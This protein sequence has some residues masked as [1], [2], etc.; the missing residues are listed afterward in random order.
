MKIE[1]VIKA[2]KKLVGE[3]AFISFAYDKVLVSFMAMFNE[4]HYHP[5][6]KIWE[7]PSTDL[8]TFIKANRKGNSFHIQYQ[9]DGAVKKQEL[10]AIPAHYS[11]KLKPFKHQIEAV[12]FALTNPRYLLADEQG[13]GKTKSCIDAETIRVME[14]GR[15]KCLIL[16][17][18]NGSKWNWK[19]EVKNN[20]YL[21]ARVLGQLTRKNGEEYVGRTID[22]VADLWNAHEHFLITNMESLRS[23]EFLTAL[24]RELKVGKIGSIIFDEIH[25]CGNPQSQQG[26]GLLSLSAPN[27]VAISGTPILNH[28]IDAFAVLKWLGKETHSMT[29]FKKHYCIMGGFG[30]N[31]ILGY[32]NM[33]ELRNRIKEIEL[34]RLKVDCL[35][36]PPKIHSDEFLEMGAKQRLIYQEIL[37]ELRANIDKIKMSPNPLTQMLRLRQATSYTGILSTSILESIK[38]DRAEQIVEEIA[39]TGGK[40]LIFSNWVEVLRPLTERLARFNPA[41]MT[42]ETKKDVEAQKSKF[43]N[44][45]SCKLCIGT[46]GFMGTSHTLTAAN[47]VIFLDEPWNKG[48]K[49]QAEDR[50]YRIGTRGTVN[51]ITLR[52][53]GTIDE[54]IARLLETKGMYADFLV[55]GIKATGNRGDL[56]EFLLS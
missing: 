51:I 12:R 31:E 19:K 18:V 40:C 13:L 41:I 35:D 5:K 38:F 2:G 7:I 42:G 24:Q 11:W 39:E 29:A 22:K 36:L 50:A 20:S 54:K 34:R 37:T 1:I 4:R 53:K 25:R 15:G 55:D 14:G 23:E 45:K 8:I 30:G 10:R 28:P 9:K 17:G 33:A 43:Q 26:K 44:D 49:E 27:M 3:S 21:S 32:K 47:T 52:C 16:C 46:I 56:V 48:T 6:E